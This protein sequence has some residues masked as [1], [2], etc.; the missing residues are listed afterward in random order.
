MF[1]TVWGF[2]TISEFSEPLMDFSEKT[3]F[4]QDHFFGTRKS[5]IARDFDQFY[6]DFNRI[7]RN[8]VLAE[9]CLTP[10]LADPIYP[11]PDNGSAL[12]GEGVVRRK[13]SSKEQKGT[14]TFCQLILIRCHNP[15]PFWGQNKP[16]STT[17]GH[18]KPLLAPP[19]VTL[20]HFQPL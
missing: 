13:R 5:M 6:S 17:L 11:V 4:A 15:G 18:F 20:S 2:S 1:S 10:S 16:F 8:L 7:P 3:P 14:A 19:S 12:S 9:N